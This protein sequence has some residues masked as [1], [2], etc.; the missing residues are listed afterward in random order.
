M[1][2]RAICTILSPSLAASSILSNSGSHFF[3]GTLV[4]KTG[5]QLSALPVAEGKCRKQRDA[6]FIEQYLC[7]IPTALIKPMITDRFGICTIRC[8]DMGEQ[9]KL[10]GASIYISLK[11]TSGMERRYGREL[12]PVQQMLHPLMG[13]YRCISGCVVTLKGLQKCFFLAPDCLTLGLR[14]IQC[15]FVKRSLL[16]TAIFPSP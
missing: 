11:W 15:I 14:S 12:Q 10:R 4:K 13:D 1:D 7:Q 8:R 6:Q 9:Q 5:L 3:N 16:A 2:Y